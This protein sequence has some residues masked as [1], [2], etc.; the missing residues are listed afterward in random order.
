[1]IIGRDVAAE[2][3]SLVKVAAVLV[4]VVVHVY[5]RCQLN[6]LSLL[7]TFCLDHATH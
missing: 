2:A 5:I 1:M 7:S 6:V 3:A 4:R